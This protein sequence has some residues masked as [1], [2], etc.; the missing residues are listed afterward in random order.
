MKI[1]DNAFRWTCCGQSPGGDGFYGC[2]H[3]GR[4]NKDGSFLSSKPC[5]C[6]FC[7]A[8]LPLPDKYFNKK[9]HAVGLDLTRGPDP[10]SKSH[11]GVL[12][13]KMREIFH[14]DR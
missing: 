1:R 14:H 13:L 12:N 2:D 6:D 10:R 11:S 5:G 4:K 7:R 8:G 3:H 9:Q